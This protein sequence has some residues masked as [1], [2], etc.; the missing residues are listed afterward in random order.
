MR[1]EGISSGAAANPAR[2]PNPAPSPR[3]W[4]Q[5]LRQRLQAVEEARV[6]TGNDRDAGLGHGESVAP[7]TS[8]SIDTDAQG[9]G[10]GEGQREARADPDRTGPELHNLPR[11][12]IARVEQTQGAARVEDE[13][14]FPCFKA[15]RYR[16]DAVGR[17]AAARRHGH[18]AHPQQA[19][20]VS[21]PH[22]GLLGTT[23]SYPA[24]LCDE[25]RPWP[26][27][28]TLSRGIRFGGRDSLRW[29]PRS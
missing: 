23:S 20:N 14:T 9:T 12:G 17:F 21:V 18:R 25:E 22:S 2:S 19:Q 28:E 16:H 29:S 5:E 1:T 8:V 26:W 10:G 6:I 11:L 27:L 13:D 4:G 3:P 24:N 7:W 15:P